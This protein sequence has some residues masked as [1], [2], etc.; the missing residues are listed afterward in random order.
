ML[1]QGLATYSP[2]SKIIRPTAPLPNCINCMAHLSVLY[3]M[4]LPSLQLLVLHTY[5]KP[6]CAINVLYVAFW[7]FVV[8]YENQELIWLKFHKLPRCSNSKGNRIVRGKLVRF[9][10]P[11]GV[12][13]WVVTRERLSTIVLVHIPAVILCKIDL[14]LFTLQ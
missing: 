11:C 10:I 5:E 9:A 6:H 3:F 7:A 8:K 13:F 2:S 4:N 1:V 12:C 14:F